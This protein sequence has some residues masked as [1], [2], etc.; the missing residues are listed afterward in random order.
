[1]TTTYLCFE[2]FTLFTKSKPCKCVLIKPK[3]KKKRTPRYTY[4]IRLWTGLNDVRF[5]EATKKGIEKAISDFKEV[6]KEHREKPCDEYGYPP[7]FD[8]KKY[9]RYGDFEE[10]DLNSAGK[11]ELGKRVLKHTL[12]LHK[13]V[14]EINIADIEKYYDEL[15]N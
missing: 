10:F 4:E 14:Q 11:G 3:P 5:F 7:V 6:C 9:D 15:N 8:V 12:K 1:M 2:C 13:W